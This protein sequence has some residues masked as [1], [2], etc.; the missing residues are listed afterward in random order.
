[1]DEKIGSYSVVELPRGRRIWVNTLELSWPAHTIYG[2]LEVDVTLARRAGGADEPTP[3][4]GTG[5]PSRASKA[6]PT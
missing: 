4:V 1:M 3:Q 2:L 5:T 6:A